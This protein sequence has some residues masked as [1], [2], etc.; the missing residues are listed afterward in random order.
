[1]RRLTPHI[2]IF[3]EIDM[4]RDDNLHQDISP[5]H[6]FAHLSACSNPRIIAD[7]IS[8]F[9][10]THTLPAYR[11]AAGTPFAVSTREASPPPRACRRLLSGCNAH[12]WGVD[13]YVDTVAL[14]WTRPVVMGSLL[15]TR[16][17]PSM[18]APCSADILVCTRQYQCLGLESAIGAL[19]SLPT[20]PTYRR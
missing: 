2:S 14:A 6:P 9:T 10:A 15:V 5:T 1:M 19:T 12:R 3:P 8:T 7:R 11:T 18:D 17:P 20:A 13:R 16:R 4:A